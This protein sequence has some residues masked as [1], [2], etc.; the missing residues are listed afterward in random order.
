[1][2]PPVLVEREFHVPF[3]GLPARPFPHHRPPREVSSQCDF[4]AHCTTNPAGVVETASILPLE[5]KCRKS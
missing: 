1:M 2:V 5:W 3:R 4:V